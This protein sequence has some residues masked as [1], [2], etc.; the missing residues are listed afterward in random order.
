MAFYKLV[1]YKAALK[2]CRFIPKDHLN[3]ILQKVT[4]LENN[5]QPFQSQKLEGGTGKEY[6]LRIGDY[7]V[8]YEIE[9][10]S[11]TITIF[12]VRHRREVYRNLG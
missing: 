10:P 11:K 6:R 9:G 5:P 1:W 8:V 3:R 7:R 12:A 2:D 4:A